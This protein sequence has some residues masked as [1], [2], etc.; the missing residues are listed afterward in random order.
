MQDL[1]SAIGWLN[2]HKLTLN[3]QKTKAMFFG[4]RQKLRNVNIETMVC[5]DS[6]IEVVQKYKYLG[7][8]LDTELKFD[9]HVRY[10]HGKIYP[11]MKTLGRIR[12]QVG[13]GTAIYLY[14]SLINPL[15]TFNDFIYASML[16]GDKAKLHVLQNSYR[17]YAFNVTSEHPDAFCTK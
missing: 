16:E 3:L 1:K 8:I 4:S 10:L 17:E 5:D 2:S 13:Q 14:N 6:E 15:F 11:K 12:T 7:M 9:Q